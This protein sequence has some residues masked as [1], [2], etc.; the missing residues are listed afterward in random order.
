MA[1]YVKNAC[2]IIQDPASNPKERAFRRA[3]SKRAPP[4][5]TPGTRRPGLDPG[6]NSLLQYRTPPRKSRRKKKRRRIRGEGARFSLSGRGGGGK[7]E[8]A[9][10]GARGLDGNGVRRG[11]R[12]LNAPDGHLFLF[13]FLIVFIFPILPAGLP[14][15]GTRFLDRRGKEIAKNK[16]KIKKPKNQ[17]QNQNRGVR[18][19]RVPSLRMRRRRRRTARQKPPS[20]VLRHTNSGL[21]SVASR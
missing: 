7:G 15:E 4:R 2:E 8:A 12:P 16:I 11:R 21:A 17:N 9:F 13:L 5:G 20:T 6:R 3:C 18:A 19:R 10:G 14:S 1:I